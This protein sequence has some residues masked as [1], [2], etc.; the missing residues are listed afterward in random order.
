MDDLK[1]GDD[2]ENWKR[3]HYIHFVEN[4]LWKRLWTYRKTDYGMKEQTNK[5]TKEKRKKK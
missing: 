2:T 5:R 4:S 3:K 1:E